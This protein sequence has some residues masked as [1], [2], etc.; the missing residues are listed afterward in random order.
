MGFRSS[1]LGLETLIGSESKA[2]LP[3]TDA[4]AIKFLHIVAFCARTPHR[5]AGPELGHA[6]ALAENLRMPIILCASR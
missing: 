6:G 1:W 5:M 2:K 3:K 4:E